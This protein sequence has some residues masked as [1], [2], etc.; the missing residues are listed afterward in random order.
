MN[1]AEEPAAICLT[2]TVS[3]PIKQQSSVKLVVRTKLN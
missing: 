3:H 1:V 2:H